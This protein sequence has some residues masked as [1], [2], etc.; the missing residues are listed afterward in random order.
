M[1]HGVLILYIEVIKPGRI[2]KDKNRTEKRI[3]SLT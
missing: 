1:G 3:N 2:K